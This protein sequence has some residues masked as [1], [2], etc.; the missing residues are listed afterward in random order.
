MRAALRDVKRSE[1]KARAHLTLQMGG[2]TRARPEPTEA[3][4]KAFAD[5]VRRLS[6]TE[7]EPAA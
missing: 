3:Q 2:V 6:R 7:P 1:A 4:R 5:S